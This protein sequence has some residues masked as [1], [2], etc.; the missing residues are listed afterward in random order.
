MLVVVFLCLVSQGASTAVTT[1]ETSQTSPNQVSLDGD[2][3]GIE[4][5]KLLGV[6]AV[7][8]GLVGEPLFGGLRLGPKCGYQL[9]L[10]PQSSLYDGVVLSD[11]ELGVV[12]FTAHPNKGMSHVPY[13]FQCKFDEGHWVACASPVSVAD[14]SPEP[15]HHTLG[16]RIMDTVANAPL[17]SSCGVSKIRWTLGPSRLSVDEIVSLAAKSHK[18]QAVLQPSLVLSAGQELR[19]DSRG[20]QVND[21]IP[22]R[23]RG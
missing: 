13:N 10:D 14:D 18:V 20:K 3:Y 15:G 1:S 17:P 9:V 4:L 2:S 6:V 19:D 5:L 11:G 7:V 22:A 21:E 23:Q 12:Y 16:I 8:Y